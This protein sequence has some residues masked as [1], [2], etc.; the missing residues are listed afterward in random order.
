[1]SSSFFLCWSRFWE[2]R[3][4]F[5]TPIFFGFSST[6]SNHQTA[7][8]P[9]SVV[10]SGVWNVRLLQFT[11]YS[12]KIEIRWAGRHTGT[13]YGLPSGDIRLV[14]QAYTDHPN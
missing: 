13:A 1:M 10:P 8:L 4:Q 3:L 11:K 6:E 7:C 14:Y 5:L 9:T 2:F 12:D